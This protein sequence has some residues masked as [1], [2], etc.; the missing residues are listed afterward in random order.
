VAIFSQ[1]TILYSNGFGYSDKK[2]QTP[3]RATTVQKT[4]S[5]SKLLLGVSIMKAQELGLLS[6]DD[7]VNDYLPFTLKNIKHPN[8]KITIRH[9]ASHTAGLKKLPKADLESLYFPTP[10]PAIKKE[11]PFGIRKVFFNKML[12]NINEN[13]EVSLEQFLYNIY[14]PNGPWY[15]KGNF[16]NAAPG[17]K[18][19]YSN[20][21]ASMLTLIIEKASK[22]PYAQFL[23]E[24]ILST[25]GMSHSG[26]DF[27]MKDY[28]EYDKSSL[29]HAGLA[30]PNDYNLV[31]YP[32]G[33]FESSVLDFSLF[34]KSMAKGYH[35]GN[36]ILSHSSFEEMMKT[37]F[38]SDFIHGVLWKVYSSGTIGHDG[39]IVGATTYSY[40]HP[41]QGKGFVLFCNTGGTKTLYKDTD[42]II[43]T[44]KSYYKKLD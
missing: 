29:Y 13:K 34:M 7:N 38:S 22:I 41:N 26:F 28:S 27:L 11:M 16:I 23:D 10:I 17:E 43:Q 25:L 5:I 8:E 24:Y 30:I 37:Q 35:S 40:Y 6:L 36:E 9:L 21:G 42:E 39:D 20:N 1:D 14:D 18:Q 12:K 19:I 15:S 4:A 3:Y 33:G 31:L 32:A 44:I 2:T